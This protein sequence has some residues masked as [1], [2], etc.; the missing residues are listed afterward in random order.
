MPVE[1]IEVDNETFFSDHIVFPQKS[2]ILTKDEKVEAK[3][4][5]R[6]IKKSNSFGTIE[7][8]FVKNLN[9]KEGFGLE[10]KGLIRLPVFEEEKEFKRKLDII[11]E[12]EQF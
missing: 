8:I 6:G 3:T 7:D 11:E 10:N 4:Q 1:T 12:I 9:K 2:S 5:I